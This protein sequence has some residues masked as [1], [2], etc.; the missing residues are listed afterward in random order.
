MINYTKI[1]GLH[2]NRINDLY[3]E[4]ELRWEKLH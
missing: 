2:Y 1:Y 4:D 3:G